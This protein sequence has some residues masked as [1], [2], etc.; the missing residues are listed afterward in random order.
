MMTEAEIMA[1]RVWEEAISPKTRED[2]SVWD[3]ANDP[4][5]LAALQVFSEQDETR[6]EM[7]AV[8]TQALKMYIFR[9]YEGVPLERHEDV[10]LA[11]KM[12]LKEEK[13]AHGEA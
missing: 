2:W 13:I 4:K 8:A 3:A 9:E 1:G 7:V 10:F 5:V 11:A 12:I 6:A